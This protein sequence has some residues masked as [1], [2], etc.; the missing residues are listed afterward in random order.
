MQ[1]S[2]QGSTLQGATSPLPFGSH[3][4]PPFVGDTA[5]WRVRCLS[6]PPQL[7]EH[8]DH[9]SHSL[10]R[11]SA[12]L[13]S[14]ARQIASCSRE[15]LQPSPPNVANDTTFRVRRLAPSPHVA[16]HWDQ[17]FQVPS[18]QSCGCGAKQGTVLQD[19]VSFRAMSLQP[20]PLMAGDVTFRSLNCWP[21]PQVLSH[22]FHS[23][24]E[25]TAQSTGSGR[26]HPSVSCKRVAHGLPAPLGAW[27]IWRL[28]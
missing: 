1:S 4:A 21:P 19:A 2:P 12:I 14:P 26:G 18:S 10:H 5:I 28:R 15:P 6:P 24:H 23:V 25:L 7:T 9:S 11:Q 8:E 17:A 13:Q 27:R 16:E 22:S 20:P 3:G